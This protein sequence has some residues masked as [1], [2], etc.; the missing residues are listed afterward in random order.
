MKRGITMILNED[1]FEPYEDDKV[2]N[3]ELEELPA[4]PK[5]QGATPIIDDSTIYV[6]EVAPD[7]ETC[8]DTY[9]DESAAREAA[10]SAGYDKMYKVGYTLKDGAYI[11]SGYEEVIEIN[12]PVLEGKMKDID[13]EIQ[14]VGGKDA[15]L[16]QAYDT[17]EDT[18]EYIRY[19]DTY[20]RSEVGNG[21]NFD[22]ITE[23]ENTLARQKDI[24]NNLTA[25]IKLVKNS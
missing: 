25:K 23:L 21:G 3:K 9:R 5:A 11:P 18:K 20:A 24:V 17:L 7:R 22:S 6:F 13:I 14:N 15:W 2:S 12:I 16:E 4:A 10:E 1:L 8:P 19:L